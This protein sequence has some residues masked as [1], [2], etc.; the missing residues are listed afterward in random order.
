MKKYVFIAFLMLCFF[1]NSQEKNFFIK[2]DTLNLKRRKLVLYTT[3]STY[4]VSMIGLNQLWYANYP[5][6]SFHGI[7]DNKEW[8][9]MD[10][11]GHALT[12]YQVG[13]LGMQVMNWSGENKK[14]QLLYGASLGFV[15]LTTVE[16]FDGF[17]KE[18]GFSTGD[19][20]ANISGTSLLIGQ[21][22]LWSE[23]RIGLKYSFHQTKYASLNQDLLG[24][25][26]V[27]QSLKDYNG[28]TYWL[29]FN[30]W[31]FNKKSTLPKWLN[32]AVG[33]GA[34]KMLHGNEIPLDNRYRQFYLSLD[35]DL[36]KIKTKSS[37]LKTLFSTINFIKI[38]A[39]TLSYSKK[40][41]FKFYGI[42]F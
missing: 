12:A 5:K 30:L 31:S 41:K 33:Y 35:V 34:E 28:Q 14:E 36:T 3:V 6:A 26:F 37:V 7:N 13:R 17:S 29:S 18:W 27:E 1:A 10:K 20:L 16:V 25:N 24:G 40:E 22:L 32:I 19:M 21:E 42:Y 11:I 8:L 15:F 4:S 39:P 2:S 9:Q 23:Q 38:P